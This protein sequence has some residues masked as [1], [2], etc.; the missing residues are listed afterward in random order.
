MF[1][2]YLMSNIVLSMAYYFVSFEGMLMNFS[3]R[4][5]WNQINNY[6]HHTY[7]LKL[8]EEYLMTKHH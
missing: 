3:I 4:K 2:V 6:Q 5:I 7:M 1:F 8:N